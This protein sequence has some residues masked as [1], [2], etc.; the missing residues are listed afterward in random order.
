MKCSQH[1]LEAPAGGSLVDVCCF[2]S[3][4]VGLCVVAAGKWAV[5]LWIQNS[6]FDW[7][8]KHTW[9]FSEPVI[10]LFPVPDS[11]GLI[12]VSLGQLEVRQL[13][14]LSCCSLRETLICEGIIHAVAGLSNSRVVS[15]SDTAEGSTLQV[16]TLSESSSLGRSQPLVSPGV[17]VSSLAPVEGLSDALIGT[18][19]GQLFI[20]NVKTGQLLNRVLL[21][22]SLSNTACLKGYSYS[23]VLLV[24]LQ[25]QLLSSL[26]QEEK[27]PREKNLVLSEDRF[28]PA[29]FSLVTINPMSGKSLLASQ[30]CPPIGWTGRLCEVDVNQ[31]SIVGLSQNGCVCVWELK[32]SGTSQTMEAPE[33]E[34]WQLARWGEGDML[35]IGHQNG[36]ISLH[37]YGMRLTQQEVKNPAHA[38]F[39]IMRH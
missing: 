33:D 3:P 20:W 38:K 5:C 27:K 30:L 37:S 23:G 31:S 32:E 25:H 15:C 11:T 36:D 12:L 9:T 4:S 18:E 17:C 1:T 22:N 2:S 10:N 24:L 21:E 26:D 14:M 8:F 6:E 28:K 29:L 39:N 16:F 34:D 13:R 19:E 7:S 35:L